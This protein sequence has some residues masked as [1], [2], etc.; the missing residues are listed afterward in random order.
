MFNSLVP[1]NDNPNNNLIKELKKQV[2]MLTNEKINLNKINQQE[3][4]KLKL[5]IQKLEK[6][7]ENNTNEVSIINSYLN[8]NTNFINSLINYILFN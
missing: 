1:D 7:N 8:N 6:T 4:L 2:E 3:R 5:K